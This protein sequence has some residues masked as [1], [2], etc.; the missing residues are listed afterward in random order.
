[1]FFRDELLS[2]SYKRSSGV[3]PESS[4]GGG[5]LNQLDLKN[6]VVS[7]VEHT[8]GRINGM[9]PKSFFEEVSKL[10]SMQHHPPYLLLHEDII[11]GSK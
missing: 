4:S 2:W 1:M 10:T 8:I 9:A 6:K 5:S 11:N 3:P 7:N